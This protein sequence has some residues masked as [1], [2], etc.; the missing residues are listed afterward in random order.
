M[1]KRKA[2][3]L[4]YIYYDVPSETGFWELVRSHYDELMELQ[5]Y[6]DD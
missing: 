5:K 2:G 4:I 3:Y 1:T 6:I